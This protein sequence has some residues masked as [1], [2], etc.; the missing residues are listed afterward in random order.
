M[1]SEKHYLRKVDDQMGHAEYEMFRA[2]PA[3]E[4]GWANPAHHMTYNEWREYLKTLINN[5]FTPIAHSKYK[6]PSYAQISYLMYIE[7]YPIGLINL[8]PRQIDGKLDGW[9]EVSYIIRPVCRHTGLGTTMLNL[10]INEAGKLGFKTL[11][12]YSN[13][14]NLASW[15]TMEKCGFRYIKETDWGSKYYELDLTKLAKV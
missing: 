3:E 8:K 12:G 11:A 1:N 14:Y 2:I 4:I 7:D 10:A 15:K 5:E 6:D 13:K 9:A